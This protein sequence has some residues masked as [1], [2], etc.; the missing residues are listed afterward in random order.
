MYSY[1]VYVGGALFLSCV[2][3]AF[4]F[5]CL[6]YISHTG[7]FNEK[8]CMVECHHKIDCSSTWVRIVLFLGGEGGKAHKACHE[9]V[10]C[11]YAFD[12]S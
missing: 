5:F 3:W 7:S 8:P 9:Y 12:L 6:L 11:C 1:C 2:C 4:L 10:L